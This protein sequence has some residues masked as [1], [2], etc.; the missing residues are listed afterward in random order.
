MERLRKLSL[1]VVLG[2][3][4]LVA[5]ALGGAV[6]AGATGDD[7]DEAPI[8]A[9]DAQRARQASER[10]VP[11]GTVGDVDADGEDGAAYEVEVRRP[12]GGAVDVLLDR[13]FRVLRTSAEEDEDG[14]GAPA[15]A[16]ARPVFSNP[17]RITNPY[18]PL[19][20]LRH[21]E[22]RGRSD[23][24]A[25][26][27]VRTRLK[28]TEPFTVHGRRIHAMVVRDAAYADGVL[29]EIALDF[30][31]QA[32]DGT[33]YYLGEDVDNYDST[34]KRVINHEGQFRYGRDTKTLG[35]A[36]PARPRPGQRFTFER[37][38]GVGTETNRVSRLNATLKV[39]FGRFDDVLVIVG[40]AEGER[41]VKRYGKGVGL[42]QERSAEGGVDLVSVRR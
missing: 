26:R 35:V 22:L 8:A 5:L 32:D 24:K 38:P 27:S 18:L 33:V 20:R 30:F 11:G 34:G 19:S 9:A 2:V 6:L 15:G 17:T 23:G 14:R 42:L 28:R 16:A 39:P 31:A 41:E 7:D 12:G 3:A 21:V 25:V 13:S 1:R 29:K 36:M 10:A 40:N 4:A 37:I